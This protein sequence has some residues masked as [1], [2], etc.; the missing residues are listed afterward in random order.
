MDI[1]A[2]LFSIIFSLIITFTIMFSINPELYSELSLYIMW[3]TIFL[4][5]ILVIAIVLYL[6]YFYIWGDDDEYSSSIPPENRPENF[7]KNRTNY[8]KG[9]TYEEQIANMFRDYGFEVDE[10]GGS[11]DQGVDLV[12]TKNNKLENLKYMIQC[13]NLNRQVKSG[14]VQKYSSNILEYDKVYIYSSQ[15]FTKSA[16]EFAKKPHLRNK[17]ILRE[18]AEL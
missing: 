15:G 16:I 14:E 12:A 10:K 4:V 17:L 8:E 18:E 9:T 11:G 2:A 7:P 1:L 13:K 6:K 5:V 3:I